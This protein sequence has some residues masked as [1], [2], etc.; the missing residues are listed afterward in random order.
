MQEFKGTPHILGTDSTGDVVAHLHVRELS[1]IVSFVFATAVKNLETGHLFLN[2]DHE[3]PQSRVVIEKG[4]AWDY[5]NRDEQEF[6]QTSGPLK[7]R[8]LLMVSP[9]NVRRMCPNMSSLALVRFGPKLFVSQVRSHG[10]TKVT[11]SYK[12]VIQERLRSSLES[13][14]LQEDSVFY[15]WALKRWSQCSKPCGGGT[16]RC[17]TASSL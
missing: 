17:S 6:L 8:V 2:D 5:I 13:N 14:L 10:D 9:S 16:T 7:Y 11:V 12:Y 4:V 15:E 3:I 1:Q